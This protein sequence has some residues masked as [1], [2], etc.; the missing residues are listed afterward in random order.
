MWCLLLALF[1]IAQADHPVHWTARVE[2][3][4]SDDSTR[5]VLH[6]RIDRFF[7]LYSTTQPPGGPVRTTIA[8]LPGTPWHMS[9]LL[10]VPPPAKMADGNFGIMTEV[11]DDSVTVGVTVRKRPRARAMDMRFAVEYQ[12]CTARYCLPARTDTVEVS[13]R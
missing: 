10:R 12:A 8:L 2:R 3:A 1:A 6:A 13:A 5:V 4:R 9:E 7:H 11:Y